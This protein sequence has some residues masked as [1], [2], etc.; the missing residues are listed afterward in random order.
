MN[1]SFFF[2]FLILRLIKCDLNANSTGDPFIDVESTTDTI[3]LT[4]LSD[5]FNLNSSKQ[6]LIEKTSTKSVDILP[7]LINSSDIEALNKF[8]ANQT[9][10]PV[11]KFTHES[12]KLNATKL[13]NEIL[14]GSSLSSHNAS[15][16][17]SSIIEIVV[18]R[19]S[20]AN[21][22][23]T[24]TQLRTAN[25]TLLSSILLR[26]HSFIQY[27]SNFSSQTFIPYV[28]LA[29]IQID[30]LY[31]Q[32]ADSNMLTTY[33]TNVFNLVANDLM[34]QECNVMSKL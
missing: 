21:Y 8:D 7:L 22:T 19:N 24:T 17:N 29:K 9:D 11:I 10:L 28:Y 27:S 6:N 15:N 25:Q 23:I 32:I 13:G 16:Q 26:M 20:T 33:A 4:S 12:I 18:T 30:G 3:K 34:N 14:N 2:F 5:F 31:K 1:L